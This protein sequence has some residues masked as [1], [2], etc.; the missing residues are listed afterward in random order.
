MLYVDGKLAA[1]NKMPE[2]VRPNPGEVRIGREGKSILGGYLDEL[3]FYSRVLS[4]E[5]VRHVM[6]ATGKER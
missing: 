5:E 3:I 6:A 4:P 2:A 1:E